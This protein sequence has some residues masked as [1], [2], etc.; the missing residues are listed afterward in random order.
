MK[1]LK[2]YNLRLDVFLYQDIPDCKTCEKLAA[3]ID[4]TLK[5]DAV[6]RDFHEDGTRFKMYSFSKMFPY[7][8]DNIYK[9]G[10]LYHFA[11]RT[12]DEQL[13]EYLSNNLPG[14]MVKEMICVKLDISVIKR[15]HISKIYTMTPAVIKCKGQGYWRSHMDINVF[16]KVIQ[17]NLEKKYKAYT[18]VNKQEKF[19]TNMFRIDNFFPIPIP[20]KNITFLT[21][22]ITICVGDDRVSQDMAYMAL[23]VGIGALNARGFGYIHAEWEEV[24]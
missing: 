22:R 2:V 7:E 14:M 10:N 4:A 12:V 3:L 8:K 1:R 24:S 16:Q 19:S 20:Y 6:Y 9:K 15:Q 21:D 5:I 13:A 23:G 18:G 11:I 17:E